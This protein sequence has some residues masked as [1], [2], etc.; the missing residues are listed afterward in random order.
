MGLIS[1]TA[2]GKDFNF[3]RDKVIAYRNFANKLWNIGRFLEMQIEQKEYRHAELVSAS[4]PSKEDKAIL[5]KLDS[6]TKKVT[7]NLEKYRFAQA[8]EDIYHFVWDDFAS[9]YLEYSK[10]VETGLKPVSTLHHIFLTSLKLLHPFMPFVTEAIW[11][12]MN[13]ELKI[14]EEPLMIQQW[15]K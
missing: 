10:T 11:Q 7:Q 3:P 2:N 1:G 4:I 14:S 15:P 12:E 9:D 8:A 5:K 13:K 6:L